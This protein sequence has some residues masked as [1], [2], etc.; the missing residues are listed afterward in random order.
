MA[1]AELKASLD[2]QASDTRRRVQNPPA[3][4]RNALGV[5]NPLEL[6]LVTDSAVPALEVASVTSV[7]TAT[8]SSEPDVNGRKMAWTTAMP[9]KNETAIAALVVENTT[10]RRMKRSMSY[11][12]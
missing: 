4:L 3:A 12:R 7:D 8:A 11:K 9:A 2:Q 6:A 10:V 1:D 5:L